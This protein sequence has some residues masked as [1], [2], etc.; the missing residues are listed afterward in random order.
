MQ[1]YISRTE[2]YTTRYLT[3]APLGWT[4]NKQEAGCYPTFDAAAE[5]RTKFAGPA[6]QKQY[7]RY[8]SIHS[9]PA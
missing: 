4:T 3:L 9:R 2:Q 6:P 8:P 7:G 5:A 1:Y